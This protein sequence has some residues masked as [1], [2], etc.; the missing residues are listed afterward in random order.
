[1]SPTALIEHKLATLQAWVVAGLAFMFV[2]AVFGFLTIAYLANHQRGE[3]RNA[4]SRSNQALACYTIPQLE[5]ARL[6]LPTLAYYKMNPDELKYQL[7]LIDKQIVLAH[8]T[9]GNCEQL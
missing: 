9:W 2:V 7:S 4:I 6:T 1:M 8:K 5:R 3:L